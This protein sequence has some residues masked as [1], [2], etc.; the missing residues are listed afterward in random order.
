MCCPAGPITNPGTALFSHGPFPD[1]YFQMR[2]PIVKPP[3]ECLEAS[4]IFTLL[5]DKLG[6]IPDIPDDL[7]KAAK[8]DRL[9]FGAKLME[10]AGNRTECT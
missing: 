6:L 1:V 9:T 8:G 10:W 3:G 7:Q 4:Q 2:R 5:A